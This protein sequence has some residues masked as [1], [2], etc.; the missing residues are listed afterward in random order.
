MDSQDQIRLKNIHNQ[1]LEIINGNF[2]FQ[3]ARTDHN[4]ELEALSA[5][6]NMVAEEI[7]DS[8]LHEGFINSRNTYK[9]TNQFTLVLDLQHII[10]EVYEGTITSL[11]YAPKDLIGHSITSL[12][13]KA[14]LKTWTSIQN[15]LLYNKSLQLI[16]NT[17]QGLEFKAKCFVIRFQN[18]ERLKDL[19]LLT[20]FDLVQRDHSIKL[21]LKKLKINSQKEIYKQSLSSKDIDN[22]RR[23]GT[24]IIDH[25]EH[26][27]PSLKDFAHSFGINE[28][29]L[30]RGFKEL[31]GMTVFQYLKIERLK[32]GH[33]LVK[34]TK[35]TFKEIAKTVGFKTP[36]HFSREFYT[37]YNYRPRTLRNN[38]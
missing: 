34:H 25:L 6:V 3:I 23:A 29:K 20:T 35:M 21:N 9:H 5:L 17:K 15:K 1:L 8:F 37:Y 26:D 33:V 22:I 36:S 13:S 18:N 2:S 38:S 30:K 14:S 12:L 27:L 16:F 19:I 31:Y 32:K 7:K 28:F 10:I 24:F 11:G 4:D